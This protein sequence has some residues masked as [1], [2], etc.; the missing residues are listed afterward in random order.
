MRGGWRE[1]LWGAYRKF[2]ESD[3]LRPLYLDDGDSLFVLTCVKTDQP[4]H[5]N[6]HRLLYVSYTSLKLF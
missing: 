3:G 4:M 5:F 1:R 2:W 6:V